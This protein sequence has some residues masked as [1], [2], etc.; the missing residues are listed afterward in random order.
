MT[1]SRE[2]AREV[3][4]ETGYS[5]EEEDRRRMLASATEVEVELY[6]PEE[7]PTFYGVTWAQDPNPR[8]GKVR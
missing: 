5:T 1:D 8:K 4:R 2:S 6:V 7:G 3:R